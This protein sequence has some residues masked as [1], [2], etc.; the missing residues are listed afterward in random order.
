MIKKIELVAEFGGISDGFNREMKELEVFRHNASDIVS[1]VAN[2]SNI[3][4]Q[5]DVLLP[6]Q[7]IKPINPWMLLIKSFD[8]LRYRSMYIFIGKMCGPLEIDTIV[9]WNGIWTYNW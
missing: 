9:C 8:A 2:G 7:K 3:V 6:G 1:D 4:I 5:L